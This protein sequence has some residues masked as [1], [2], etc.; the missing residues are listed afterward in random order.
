MTT[1]LAAR[2]AGRRP[3]KS[4]DGAADTRWPVWRN[5][6]R[7]FCAVL[8]A[9][10]P[11]ILDAAGAGVQA[12]SSCSGVVYRSVCF[13]QGPISFADELVSFVPGSGAID[14]EGK[15]GDAQATLGAPVPRPGATVLPLGC[16]GVLTLRFTDN[17]LVDI[18]GPDLYVFEA[19]DAPEPTSIEIS[20]DGVRWIPIGRVQ[21]EG[22][23]QPVD[24]AGRVSPGQTFQWVRLTNASDICTSS[25]GGA[26]IDAV[27]AIGSA[28]RVS[29]DAA[30]LFATGSAR[31]KANAQRALTAVEAEIRGLRGAVRVVI[32]GHTD[33]VGTE[34]SNQR[35]SEARA[36]A[37]QAHLSRRRSFPETARVEVVGYGE[38]R[39]Q[40]PNASPEQRAQNRRVDVLILPE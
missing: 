16:N 27:G 6:S 39:P 33:D 31:L 10:L 11:C 29:I 25:W 28:R 40:R 34:A 38:S 14:N 37:V 32:E 7:I 5:V 8:F 26:D 18:P 1:F 24:I 2:A 30:V 36:K 13:P 17:A 22:F 19:G 4:A 12:S 35:L 9:A 23:T 3:C 20:D 21:G 15:P